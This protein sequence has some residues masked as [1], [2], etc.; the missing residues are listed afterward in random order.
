M[1]LL[2]QGAGGLV[3]ALLAWYMPGFMENSWLLLAV[4]TTPLYILGMPAFLLV[5]RTIPEGPKTPRYRPPLGPW[6]FL[7]A[8]ACCLGLGYAVNLV[9]G[10]ITMGLQWLANPG[11]Q[12]VT[13]SLQEL[14]LAG[15]P[16]P[17]LVFAV[18]LPA[19]GEEFLFRHMLWRKLRG[20][21][22]LTTILFSALCFGLFHANLSQVP[23][24]F[25]IGAILGWLYVVFGKLWLTMLAH[26]IVN[27][28]GAVVLPWVM[29][30]YPGLAN[31]CALA[32]VG[33]LIPGGIALFFVFRR[34]VVR[35]LL[36]PTQ[37]GW[38]WRPARQAWAPYWQP[39]QWPAPPAGGRAGV[40]TPPGTPLPLGP[41]T[42]NPAMMAAVFGP[43]AGPHPAY[44]PAADIPAGRAGRRG[45]GGAAR[46]CLANAGMVL[47]M[48]VAGLLTLFGL[49]V[50]LGLFA[51]VG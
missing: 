37:P 21:G 7:L 31:L 47:Y 28:L 30:E 18:A 26:F 5:L 3:S 11:A 16:L 2:F 48:V 35:A 15:G 1:M 6:R 13:N 41:W 23:Y 9:T 49:A 22:E 50:S 29:A 34:R 51:G 40:G 12:D 24:T 32:M 33:L 42:A 45:G 10:F 8:L 43:A 46:V 14:V 36:P 19:V 4:S 38:P 44:P 17:A 20:S 25:V 39:P 27:L